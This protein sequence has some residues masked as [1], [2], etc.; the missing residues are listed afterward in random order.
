[1]AVQI[2]YVREIEF[3][4][5]ACERVS[6]LIRRVVAN[7]P[8]AFTYKGTGTYIIGEG[9]VAV[10][11]PGPL[12]DAHLDALLRALEGETVSLILITHTH[13]DHSPAAKPLKALTGAQTCGFGPHGSGQNR[14][15]DDVQ[16]E[17]DGDMDF[18]P[19]VELRH[20]DIV[21]G[22]GW[23]VECVYT[24]GH[25]SNHMCFALKEE[26]ALFT[27]DHVMGWST[28]IVSPPDGNMEQYMASLRLLL[29]RDDEIYWPTHGPAITEPK[30]F[31]RSFIE[32]REDRERQIVEQLAAGRTR[33]QDMVPIM[34]AAVDKRL[35][36]AAARS[37]LAHMEHLVARG[38]VRTEG[39]PTL[40]SEYR[41]A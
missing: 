17:E 22:D 20:G 30:P 18:V 13:S 10:I 25:T 36:P 7:N 37:V 39:R 34:Y 15:S 9:D 38:A 5:G 11:D 29:T 23:T 26:K 14:A 27:G 35:Y 31:V 24:P 1:M 28:S 4:Y 2:P 12:L 19:D 21:E 3:E 40:G 32:H 6:P 33:I 8:S 41:L 16:V